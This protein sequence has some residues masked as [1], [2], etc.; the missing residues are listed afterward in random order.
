MKKLIALAL[1]LT[2]TASVFAYSA[3]R[4]GGFARSSSFRAS[5]SRSYS[6][7][8]SR[9]SYSAPKPVSAPKPIE[10]PVSKP[11]MKAPVVAPIAPVVNRK[12]E[13]KKSVV[14]KPV[15]ASTAA[16]AAPVIHQTVVQP[17]SSSWFSPTNLMLGWLL[18]GNHTQNKQLETIKNQVATSTATST[19]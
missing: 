5:P 14:N 8:V 2:T 18:W 12:K 4:A 10:K 7:P 17:Q 1:L 6:R 9:P 13:E 11:V 16:A 3:A 15:V 19:K